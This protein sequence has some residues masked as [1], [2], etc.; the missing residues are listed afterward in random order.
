MEGCCIHPWKV[1]E[2]DSGRLDNVGKERVYHV[3]WRWEER[4]VDRLGQH[5]LLQQRSV[6]SGQIL[7]SESVRKTVGYSFV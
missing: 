5:I 6:L 2:A 1:L 3:L 7:L 4:V